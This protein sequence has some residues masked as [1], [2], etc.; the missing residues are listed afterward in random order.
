MH[1][2]QLYMYNSMN[3]FTLYFMQQIYAD[4]HGLLV[5]IVEPGPR[6]EQ[7]KIREVN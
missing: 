3:E 5:V 7:K 4:N 1:K 2:L 6:S